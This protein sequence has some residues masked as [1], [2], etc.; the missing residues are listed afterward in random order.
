MLAI[1]LVW[2]T[3]ALVACNS[4]I[5]DLY[6]YVVQ[7]GWLLPSVGTTLGWILARI[8]S[9]LIFLGLA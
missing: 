2:V 1:G 6:L 9:A 4:L 3:R 5:V 8:R 7:S